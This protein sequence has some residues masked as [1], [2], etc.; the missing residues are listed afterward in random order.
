M[1]PGRQSA[2]STAP[3]SAHN[4]LS[5]LGWL[6]ALG[7]LLAA[8]G[9]STPVNVLARVLAVIPVHATPSAGLGGDSSAIWVPS[10]LDGSIS[11]V[12]PLTNEVSATIQVATSRSCTLCWGAVTTHAGSVWATSSSARL[13]L[14]GIDPVSNRVSTSVALPVFPSAVMS[15]SDGT[16][17]IASVL[18]SAV[19]KFDPLSQQVQ[20]RIGVPR[21][22]RLAAGDGA[23]W[24]ISIPDDAPDGRVVAIDTRT[25]QVV[26]NVEVGVQPTAIAFGEGGVWVVDEGRQRL[27]RIDPREAAV[28][29]SIPVGFLPTGVTVSDGS[30]W[31]VSLSAPGVDGP[32][33][34]RIDPTTNTNLGSISVG[35][36]APMGLAVGAG[37]L[38]VATRNPDSIVRV[39]ASG[40]A[41]E[42]QPLLLGVVVAAVLVALWTWRQSAHGP[43]WSPADSG[44]QLLQLRRFSALRDRGAGALDRN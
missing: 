2:D 20:A 27:Q 33:L 4:R 14:L 18:D 31:V 26:A 16:V 32:A 34:S 30:I 37:S 6:G 8:C 22:S 28:V 7:L 1:A 5:L 12:D 19:V 3:S 40:A 29:A 25:D 23:V 24:V 21:P 38:W 11:R 39:Q 44:R 9:P 17:W 41:A 42:S 35:H 15:T 36:G 43:R 13:A 10:D